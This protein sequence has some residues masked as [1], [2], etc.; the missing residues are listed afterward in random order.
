MILFHAKRDGTVTT[1]PQL[2]P[3]GSSM[4]DLMVVS[5][6][7]YAYCT[8]KLTPASGMY[9]PDIPCTPILQSNGTTIWTA[10]LPPEATVVAGSVTY[11]LI[12]TAADGTRQGTLDGCFTVPRGAI[13]NTPD[14]VGKLEN[15]TVND[16]YT[17]LS[18]IYA[19]FVGHE[20]DIN[21]LKNKVTS[22][23]IYVGSGEMPENCILQIILDED[24]PDEPEEPEE[25]EDPDEPN[26]AI[27]HNVEYKFY[28]T[29]QVL[30]SISHE[31]KVTAGE[32]LNKT[33]YGKTGQ[34]TE[35]ISVQMGETTITAA[36]GDT[37]NNGIITCFLDADGG[38]GGVIISA[39]TGDVIVSIVTAKIE[40]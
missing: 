10:Y 20:M 11:Q 17:V 13:T 15:K 26:T 14:T 32:P 38:E 5:E 39:V 33:I 28:D 31:G 1:T 30:T 6:F 22:G 18:N 23:E 9:I 19:S 24:E 35:S 25:P 21:A 29:N 37:K 8:I 36:R 4:Q 40:G 34:T 16:L 3:H 2:V 7:D 27:Q 12:F